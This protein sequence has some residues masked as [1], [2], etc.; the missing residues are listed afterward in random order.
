[1]INYLKSILPRIRPHRKA[2]DDVATFAEKEWVLLDFY[3]KYAFVYAVCDHG[4]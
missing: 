3:R 2:L 4:Y 1:M